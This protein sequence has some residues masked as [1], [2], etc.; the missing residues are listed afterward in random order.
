MYFWIS[1]F[2]HRAIV[3]PKMHI[4]HCSDPKST[5]SSQKNFIRALSPRYLDTAALVYSWYSSDCWEQE[6][7]SS[8]MIRRVN[9]LHRFLL[10]RA[11]DGEIDQRVSK[12]LS[13]PPQLRES[14]PFTGLNNSLVSQNWQYRVCV[15]WRTMSLYDYPGPY[16][17]YFLLE[18][19]NV[20]M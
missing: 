10:R 3:V 14:M 1:A 4:V 15:K 12:S 16:L 9:A 8:S 18:R 11:D 19:S 6:S 13:P 20:A 17:R 7:L 2:D 5:N